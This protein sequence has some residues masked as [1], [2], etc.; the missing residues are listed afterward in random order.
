MSVINVKNLSKTYKVSLKKPGFKGTIDHFF[1]RTYRDIVAVKDVSFTINSGEIVGFLGANGAGKTT[2]LK[3]LTGLIHPSNGKIKI[4]DRTPFKRHPTFL[5]KMSLVMGQKQQLLW[6]LPALDSLKINAAV[7]EI[8]DKIFQQRLQELSEMLSIKEQLNQPVRKLSLGQRMK[9]ELLAALLHHPQVLFLD[10][11]TLGLD[12]NSQAAIRSFLKE[13][14]ERY[15]ATILLT[16]HYM[17]DITALCER[18]LLIHE[19]QLIYD[20]NLEDLVEKFTPYKEVNVELSYPLSSEKL[21][22][23]GQVET[24][25][26][27]EVRFLVK[28]EDLTD[29]IAKILAQLEVNDLSV[30][31]PPIEE[32]VSQI[33]S[34]GNVDL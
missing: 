13:Y 17:A 20:G 23:Y 3:M 11:P 15:E 25:K 5:K 27:Q 21:A 18:V 4:V 34:R 24:M 9:A 16:S 32:V 7:Y 6:D 1:K 28:Q 14:N 31:D 2:T 22:H 33:F 29:T 19:G 12:V 8:P 30:S 10:E 26:G